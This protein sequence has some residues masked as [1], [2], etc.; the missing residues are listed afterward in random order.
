M[1]LSKG[2]P[3]SKQLLTGWPPR[4]LLRGRHGR[5]NPSRRRRPTPPLTPASPLPERVAGKAGGSRGQRWRGSRRRPPPEQAQAPTVEAGR[6]NTDVE[7]CAQEEVEAGNEEAGELRRRQ[8][9]GRRRPAS[10]SSRVWRG[11]GR[12]RRPEV[13][14]RGAGMDARPETQKPALLGMAVQRRLATRRPE[15]Q[16]RRGQRGGWTVGGAG[17]G[18]AA[19]PASAQAQMVVQRE[20]AVVGRLPRCRSAPS[21]FL[22]LHPFFA[23]SF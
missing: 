16:R 11:G 17:A 21:P 18:T 13:G 22:E 8:R 3:Q 2:T 23:G 7:A 4:R 12:G 14:A 1:D 15:Q 20:L 10:S 5:R 9:R 6:S 19:F